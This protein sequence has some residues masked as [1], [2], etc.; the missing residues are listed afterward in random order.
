MQAHKRKLFLTKQVLAINIK[1]LK[2]KLNAN[3]LINLLISITYN[4][5]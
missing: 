1:Y 4:A 2:T 5:H 3:K